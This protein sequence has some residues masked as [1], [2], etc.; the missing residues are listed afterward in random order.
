M[1]PDYKNLI[2]FKDN[3][4]V[5]KLKKIIHFKPKNIRNHCVNFTKTTNFKKGVLD[6]QKIIFLSKNTHLTLDTNLW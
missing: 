4:S 1:T 3:F 2:Y 5:K 6:H